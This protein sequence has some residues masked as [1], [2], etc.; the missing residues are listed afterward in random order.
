MPIEKI[1]AEYE[2]TETGLAEM[3]KG[4]VER[5][6]ASGAFDGQDPGVGHQ[7]A[8]RMTSAQAGSMR[9]TLEY[10]DKEYGGAEGYMRSKCGLN[11]EDLVALRKNLIVQDENG[12]KEVRGV[13]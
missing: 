8:M 10:I 11:D 9:R 6:M 12:K 5:I 13:L 2:L 1:C 3:R 4:F 7:A